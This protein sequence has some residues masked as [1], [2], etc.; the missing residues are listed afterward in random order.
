MPRPYAIGT[1]LVIAGGSPWDVRRNAA[2]HLLR[3]GASIQI[4]LINN[5]RGLRVLLC[6]R[7]CRSRITSNSRGH[8]DHFQVGH[9]FDRSV[10]DGLTLQRSIRAAARDLPIVAQNTAFAIDHLERVN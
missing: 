2:R 5:Q 1:I 10:T 6:A 9:H 7:G 8:V 3:F 4:K